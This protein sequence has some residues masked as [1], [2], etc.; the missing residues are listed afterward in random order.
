MSSYPEAIKIL[1]EVRILSGNN[2]E[3]SDDLERLIEIS[4]A[5]GK[6]NLLKEISFNAKFLRGLMA[7]IQK[8]D[9]TFDDIYFEKVKGELLDGTTKIKNQLSELLESSSGFIRNVFEEKYMKLTQESI[10]NL[11]RFCTDLSYLK[12]Y[13]NDQKPE[14]H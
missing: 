7:V 5:G 3:V 2:L 12:L 1:N 8:R 4:L 14:R 13:F 6:I 10:Q 9:Q 11:Y